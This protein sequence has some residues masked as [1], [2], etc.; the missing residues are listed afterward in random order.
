MGAERGRVSRKME[1]LFMGRILVGS[2]YDNR[3]HFNFEVHI[4]YP[5]SNTEYAVGYEF[6]IP[7]LEKYEFI[8]HLETLDVMRASRI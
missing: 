4:K 2:G 5:S 7:N 8:C 3:G 1:V 6:G